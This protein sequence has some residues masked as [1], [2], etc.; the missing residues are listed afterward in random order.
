M[1]LVLDLQCTQSRA[2]AD[3]GIARYAIELAGALHR[4][5]ADIALL[6]L[7]PAL[8]FPRSLPPDLAAHPGLGWASPQAY[9]RLEGE[10]AHVILS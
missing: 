7:N 9:D 5:G 2:H 10:V 6:T 4:G 3:R 1:R 8:P